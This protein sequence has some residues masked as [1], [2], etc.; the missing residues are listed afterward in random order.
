M[1][2]GDPFCIGD[3]SYFQYVSRNSLL[4]AKKAS[5]TDRLG[6]NDVSGFSTS[7]AIIKALMRMICRFI[8]AAKYSLFIR[9]LNR[10]TSFGQQIFLIRKIK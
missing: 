2:F 10:I 4:I 8:G 9:Y 5:I 1:E 3:N 6:T 7:A